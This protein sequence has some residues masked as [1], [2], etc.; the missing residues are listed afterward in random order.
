LDFNGSFRAIL[1]TGPAVPALLRIFQIRNIRV[2]RD[3]HVYGVGW[4]DIVTGATARAFF[5]VKGGWH[6]FSPNRLVSRYLSSV[7]AGPA[8]V[9]TVFYIN[10]LRNRLKRTGKFIPFFLNNHETAPLGVVCVGKVQPVVV[11]LIPAFRTEKGCVRH[12]FTYGENGPGLVGA[13]EFMKVIRLHLIQVL[14]NAL[15]FI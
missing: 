6:F 13:H 15:K 4:T 8:Q 12:D 7:I 5:H 2:L 10:V 3:F 14:L 1:P 9:A 11:G